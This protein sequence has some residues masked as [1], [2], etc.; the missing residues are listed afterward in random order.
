MV[1]KL[2]ALRI[3]PELD[4]SRYVAG[5]SAVE[6]A[7]EGMASSATR[8]GGAIKQSGERI[9]EAG[10]V[11]ARLS[12][13][14]IDGYSSQ[15]RFEKGL[16]NL[17][18]AL[19]TGNA[20]MAQAEAILEGMWRRT[21]MM[22]NADELAAQGKHQ[23]AAAV[24]AVN[25]RL[26]AN[27]VIADGA[28]AAQ[29]RLGNATRMSAMQQR[30]LVFQLNDVAVSLASGMNPLM[31]FMQQ[32]S[33]IATIYGPEEGGVGKAL[34]ETGKLA[35]SL[36]SK[37]LPLGI[38]LGGVA[39]GFAAMT[40]EINRN[41]ETQVSMGDVFMATWELASVA[42]L[43]FL[44]PVADWFA[45]LWD[46][47]SPH[48]SAAMNSLIGSFDL[49]FRNIKTIWNGLAPALGDFAIS[50]VN[51]VIDA[52]EKMLN[53]SRVQVIAFLL[54]TQQV[55]GVF[56][57]AAAGVAASSL[58]AAG[59]FKFGRVANPFAGAEDGFQ[60]EM[61]QN[62][63]DVA[64]KT[65]EGG[66]VADIGTRARE[67]AGRPSK[68]EEEAAADAAKKAAEAYQQV[69][70][71]AQQRI[72]QLG[73]EAMTL[74]MTTAAAESL[75]NTQA[76]MAEAEASGLP[77]TQERVQQVL[78]LSDAMTDAQLTLEGLQLQMENR[79][80]WEIMGAELANL[81]EL[82]DRGKIGWDDYA[83]SA[84]RAVETMAGQYAAGA[85]D[86]IGNL[87]KLTDAM[88]L[89]GKAAFDVQKTLGIARAVV[90]GGEAIVHS[91]NA[92]AAIGGPPLG[93]AFAG[94]AAAATAAQIAAI[95]S[96]TYQS[97][98]APKA[99]GGGSGAATQ[100]VGSAQQTEKTTVNIMMPPGKSRWTQA[101]LEDLV[102]ELNGVASDNL[103]IRTQAA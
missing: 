81:Q 17:D 66:Y 71:K 76:L 56:G 79:T 34:E 64:T 75:R 40:H 86:V 21:S 60:R 37:F 62:Q 84:G 39:A 45:G 80:P 23:L 70:D 68:E 6:H 12:H 87:E 24:T 22:A 78:A 91:F 1:T 69:I 35:T 59:D 65:A 46:D 14:Y 53:E 72:D 13:Q 8:A 38:V 89:E 30:N 49:A 90:S 61:A 16:S 19:A 54:Q 25:A 5:A 63:I 88:G 96:T 29:L 48:I 33:Q 32:G 10:N 92:G 74:G 42:V 51:N 44:Q 31:V 7:N 93:F 98:S 99:M 55:L 100:P 2:A 103:I 57:G 28:T 102:R 77:M 47:I 52:I 50:A 41:A 83:I 15:V 11:V 3:A 73:L 82:L 58:A 101:E 26:A 94:I 85:N 67:I 95:A 36:V 20:S 97:K 27:E 43:G 9:S 18:R 4:P